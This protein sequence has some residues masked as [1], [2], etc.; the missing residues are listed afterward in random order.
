MRI[1]EQ[2]T[3][4]GFLAFSLLFLGGCSSWFTPQPVSPVLQPLMAQAPPAEDAT[5]PESLVLGVAWLTPSDDAKTLPERATRYL[6]DQIQDHFSEPEISLRVARVDSV[7]SVDLATLRQLGQQQGV[8]HMLVV[9]PTV[10]EIEVPEKFGGPR[11][12]P[13]LG[14]RTESQVWL[15]A[16]AI[17]L[18]SGLPIFQ[19]QGTALASLEVLDYGPIGDFPRIFRGIYFPGYGNIYYPTG[20]REDFPPGEVR[21]LASSY[22][23]NGLLWKLDFIKTSNPS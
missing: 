20:G 14:T 23:L 3:G 13:W 9:A 1:G 7:T 16:V 10:Q 2:K 5:I 21:V 11:G 4:L 22:A 6:L 12:G 19:A 17:E 8:T 18:E 15:E